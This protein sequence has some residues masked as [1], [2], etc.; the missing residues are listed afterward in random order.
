MFVREFG[1]N[2]YL[3]SARPMGDTIVPTLQAQCN[4]KAISTRTSYP[5]PE[6]LGMQAQGSPV[7]RDVVERGDAHKRQGRLVHARLVKGQPFQ[8]LLPGLVPSTVW[9]GLEGGP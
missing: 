3:G 1:E 8:H 6:G 7:G 2:P 9:V 4:H 5:T